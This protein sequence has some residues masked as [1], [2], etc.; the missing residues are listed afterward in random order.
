MYQISQTIAQLVNMFIM[1][2]DIGSFEE[3]QNAFPKTGLY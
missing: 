1:Y 2:T 3:F